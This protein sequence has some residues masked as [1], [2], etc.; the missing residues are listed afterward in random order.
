MRWGAPPLR[1][2]QNCTQRIVRQTRE[3]EKM[4]KHTGGNPPLS[5]TNQRKEE[6]DAKMR[7]CRGQPP[8]NIQKVRQN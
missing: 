3:E 1:V 7:K 6:K 5:E 4:H 2:R 8:L